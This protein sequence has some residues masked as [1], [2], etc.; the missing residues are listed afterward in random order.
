MTQAAS[1]DH[2]NPLERLKLI[3][4]DDAAIDAFLDEMEVTSPREREMLGE[5]AR[6]Q[7]LAW[8]ERF[9][10]DHKRVITALESLRRHGYR[11]SRA[12]D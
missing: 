2:V 5:L 10:E 4:D 1:D 11:G 7:T 8:P 3:G 12:G 9:V 6:A